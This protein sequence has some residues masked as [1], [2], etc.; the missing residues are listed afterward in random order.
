MRSG[1]IAE[2]N[3]NKPYTIPMAS[4]EQL[5][6]L[7][8][9]VQLLLEE[10]INLARILFDRIFFDIAPTKPIVK[11]FATSDDLIGSYNTESDPVAMQREVLSDSQCQALDHL[12]GL[13][14]DAAQIFEETRLQQINESCKLLLPSEIGSSSVF[15]S[16]DR[17]SS[18]KRNDRTI[19]LLQNFLTIEISRSEE[20][21][22]KVKVL[23]QEL[24]DKTDRLLRASNQLKRVALRSKRV[25]GVAEVPSN[26][27]ELEESQPAIEADDT[28]N[29]DER[30]VDVD[31]H[32]DEVS[33]AKK[34]DVSFDPNTF[35]G[36]FIRK[37]FEKE[38][39]FGLVINYSH[40]Y[41]LVSFI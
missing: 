1:F 39:Y 24:V 25:N 10:K 34:A 28:A 9:E 23:E 41:F 5:P 6:H 15:L 7:S 4:R 18:S 29:D 37:K 17:I 2:I 14:A 21:E 3:C 12:S 33:E 20:L 32:E 35:S 19:S 22:S 30:N 38:Y 11:T 40:P 31:D 13:L 36:T 8:A 26:G 16:K 27:I